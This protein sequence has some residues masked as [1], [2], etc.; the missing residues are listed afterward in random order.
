LY[1]FPFRHPAG[2]GKISCSWKY[3]NTRFTDF[4]TAAEANLPV[5][6]FYKDEWVEGLLVTEYKACKSLDCVLENLFKGSSLYFTID[7]AG[8]VII[9]KNFVISVRTGAKKETGKFVSNAAY[10]DSIEKQQKTEVLY[11]EIGKR[12]DAGLPGN[13]IVSGYV[14]DIE[15]KEPLPGVTILV[16][17]RNAGAVTNT[18]GYYSVSLPRGNHVIRFSFI[19]MR[20]TR[21][22]L[23]LNGPEK[24]SIS[25]KS[26]LIS[27]KE[28]VISAERNV[29]LQRFETGVEKI[30]VPALKMLPAYMGE[31]D[32]IK[33]LMLVTG[34]QSAGEGAAGFNVRG[35]SADQ[36][37][38]LLNNATIYNSS[39]FFG[40]FS[41]VNSEIIKDVTLYKGGIPA[42]FGGRIS[43]VLDIAT[44]DGDKKDFSGNAGISPVT[45]HLTVEGPIIK[46][47]LSYLFAGR[48]TYSDWL[49]GLLKNNSLKNSKAFF[50]D[51]NGK[52]S[53]SLNRNNKL[54]LSAY[55]SHDM[56]SFATNTIY[57]YEN[58][59]L[60]LNW[61]HF[62]DARFFFFS[63][64]NSN[65]RYNIQQNA[66][67]QE[68]YIQ[69]HKINTTSFRSDF[70]IFKG[71]HE[72]NFGLDANYHNLLPGSYLPGSDSSIMEK[73]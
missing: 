31:P 50:F 40:F 30:N 42:C 58:M 51:L 46:D 35:G 12:A 16:Q 65:Y 15:T 24:M 72:V 18:N 9:T 48:T 1:F 20:E 44:R 55:L 41:A 21:V 28:T 37:L 6:F 22:N 49:L 27:L 29:V 39:H 7:E 69:T 33:S 45:A 38:I 26:I 3:A 47:T 67:P 59:V 14:K 68:E 62:Y 61:K 60:S 17:N 36:N 54:D 71:L 23:K 10:A 53:Y 63:L 57:N 43:S 34:V 5:R 4:V 8:N 70:N 32:I 25:M 2:P 64:T 13:V 11:L 52:I 73:T 56:F 66:I 19:G